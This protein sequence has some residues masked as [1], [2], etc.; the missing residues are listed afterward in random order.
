M[1]FFDHFKKSEVSKARKEAERNPNPVTIEAY[2]RALM[3]QSDLD[4]ALAQATSGLERF[5]DS[6]RLISVVKYVK[7][8]QL[9]PR[10]AELKEKVRT[11]PSPLLYRQL[12]ELYRDIGDDQRAL[13]TCMEVR[14]RY[15]KDE[16]TFLVMGE[17]FHERFQAAYLA[18]D[19]QQAV[20][21]LQR[22]C[23]L[24][25]NNYNALVKLA[26]LYVSVGLFKRAIPH[27]RAIIN[28]CFTKSQEET[29]QQLRQEIYKSLEVRTLLYAN[30]AKSAPLGDRGAFR[31]N[32]REKQGGQGRH[33][34]RNPRDERPC[35]NH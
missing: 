29:T 19:G 3:A 34:Q 15:P 22:A 35:R 14:E 2:C 33:A 11:N 24:N 7:K 30:L 5:P 18:S 6:D 27:L 31:C 4:G 21:N 28:Y 1:G 23:E 9:G 10:V 17:I 32:G 20:E 16:N 25:R 13:D 8:N 12:A 26:H